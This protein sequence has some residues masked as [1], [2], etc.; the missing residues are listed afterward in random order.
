MIQ[1]NMVES[2]SNSSA[3][4]TDACS[5]L[6]RPMPARESQASW[7]LRFFESKLFDMSIAISYLFNSKEPGVKSYLCNRLFTFSNK[8]V[9]FYL[10]QLLN[11]YVYSCSE[12][13][14]QILT[15]MLSSYFRARCSCEKTGIDF[16]LK[17]SWLL[18][19]HIND[20]ARLAIISKESHVRRSLNKAIKLYKLVTSDK[21]KQYSNDY[22]FSPSILNIGNNKKK[23]SGTNGNVNLI[24]SP[25]KE[26]SNNEDQ[27]NEPKKKK[28]ENFQKSENNACNELNLNS[29]TN[30]ITEINHDTQRALMTIGDLK[31]GKAFDV[32]CIC[33]DKKPIYKFTQ[34]NK[35]EEWSEQPSTFCFTTKP[36]ENKQKEKIRENFIEKKNDSSNGSVEALGDLIVSKNIFLTRSDCKCNAM[37]I[38][39]EMEF[40]KALVAIG[41][42]LVRLSSKEHKN[43]RLMSELAIV[44]MNLPARVWLP[45]YD[46]AHQI[47]RIPYRSAAVL[48]SKEKWILENHFTAFFALPLLDLLT[49]WS[50]T[51]SNCG[52]YSMVERIST[53]LTFISRS[54]LNDHFLNSSENNRIINFIKAPYIVYV[55]V[56]ECNDIHTAV[57]PPK[58]L[59]NN[60]NKKM[61]SEEALFNADLNNHKAN[62]D[63]QLSTKSNK[64]SSDL[65]LSYTSFNPSNSLVQS[66]SAILNDNLNGNLNGN[67]NDNL[68]DNTSDNISINSDSALNVL[69][70]NAAYSNFFFQPDN[71]SLESFTSGSKRRLEEED[72]KSIKSGLNGGRDPQ[73]PSM[74][75]LKEP[76]SEKQSRIKE[77]SP[78]GHYSNWKL[79]A[80][81]VKSG[82]DLRQELMAFQFLQKLQEI[83]LQEHVKVFVRPTRILVLSKDSGMIEPILNAVSLHQI[84]KLQANKRFQQNSLLDYF[85]QE[86][87]PT[88]TCEYFLTAQKNFVES[89]AGYS[90]ACYLLQVKDRHNGNILL[91]DHGHLIHIDFGFMLSSSP[92]NLGFESSAFKMTHEFVEIMGG[93]Q[94]DMFAYFKILMLKGFL[95]ARKHMDKLVPIIEI[96]QLSSQLPCFQK[97]PATII[98]QLKDRFHLNLTEEQL[99]IQIDT[100]IMNSMNSF[101]TKI[102]DNFQYYTNDIH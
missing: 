47:V 57:L 88:K 16:S 52:T 6:N 87:G 25:V 18:D 99:Q 83:W 65:Y 14:D 20:N 59:E 71:L 26:D 41:K 81:I 42:K 33:A 39:P 90:I 21:L 102:Y 101:T 11:I 35:K 50:F 98:R 97:A 66:S 46:F 44:N 3:N 56:L 10:P 5:T 84:K 2:Q 34:K 60:L 48:N 32:H 73:D 24:G 68:N 51:M 95:A 92:K 85:L 19:A 36:H 12:S 93:M 89:C 7:L 69:R 22:S 63:D 15:D 43:Q 54:V 64:T 77:S 94:S 80:V 27:Q 86:F 67:L 28:D 37:R 40:T 100:M 17:C 82:D 53:F 38:E 30:E 96:M 79:L 61:S 49:N 31:S 75:A 62:Q 23:I 8:D 70:Q 78:Y 9:D 4:Q 45:L 29:E 1:P 13:N 76:W 72:S 58:L 74:N 91:D 55:E